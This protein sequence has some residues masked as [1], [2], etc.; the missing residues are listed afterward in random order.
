M[1]NITINNLPKSSNDTMKFK[2]YLHNH[3]YN[4]IYNNKAKIA[5]YGLFNQHG[6]II[7]GLNYIYNSKDSLVKIEI[8]KDASFLRDSIIINK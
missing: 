3:N 7:D 6:D 5:K 4:A 1:E 8:Y 2:P